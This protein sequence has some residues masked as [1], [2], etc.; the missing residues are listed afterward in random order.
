MKIGFEEKYTISLVQ[1]QNLIENA[2]EGEIE[3]LIY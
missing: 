1:M 3:N 2:K